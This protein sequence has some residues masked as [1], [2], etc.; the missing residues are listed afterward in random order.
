MRAAVTPL[1]SIFGSGFLI[2]V[3]VLER[4]VGPWSVVAMAGVCL[5]AWLVGSATRHAVRV[6][7][8]G[9]ADGTLDRLTRRLDTLAGGV[10][11]VAYLIS[12]ALY[13]RIMADYVV[14]W[15]VPAGD[16]AAERL[17]AVG[18]LALITTIGIVRGF[19]GLD[20]LD[21]WSLGAVLLLVSALGL[22]LLWHDIAHARAGTLQLPPAPASHPVTTLLVLGGILITVQGFE[23]VRFLGDEYGP[24]DRVNG[25]RLAQL[26]STAVY[27]GFVAVATPVMGLGGPDGPDATLLDITM[28]VT[29]LLTA[30]LVLAALFSQL[31]A[32]VADTEAANGNLH[33]LWPRLPRR[34]PYLIIGG[35]A[36]A[37]AATAG[38]FT[39][40][41][42]A[43]RA[44][45]AYYALQCVIA[46]RTS[47]GTPRRI[48]YG[49][50]AAVL[51]AITL[52]AEPVG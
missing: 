42:V 24:R 26:V 52:F 5:L 9:E 17:L 50:L 30:P 21:R 29:P 38:T 34:T 40:V 18:A 46:V 19:H 23:V 1:A 27:L 4:A 37:L 31:A 15:F 48:G 33:G 45:A 41:M 22:T 10:I 28:R 49:L 20:L 47:R 43:S 12:V 6:V 32:A 44:F 11:V 14:R 16:A 39:I 2:V 25:S 7:E 36:A 13:L 35:A 8:P 51:V 3:P